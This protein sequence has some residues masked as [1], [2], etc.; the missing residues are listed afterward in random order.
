MGGPKDKHMG[1]PKDKLMGGP[2]NRPK[3][4]QVE[5]ARQAEPGLK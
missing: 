5:P 4:L 2:K 1:G 3:I